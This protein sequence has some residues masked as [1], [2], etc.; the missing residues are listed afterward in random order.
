MAEHRLRTV[1]QNAPDLLLVDLDR[2]LRQM[3]AGILTVPEAIGALL[4]GLRRGRDPAVGRL[5]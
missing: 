4:P 3:R 2:V 5:Q 1:L